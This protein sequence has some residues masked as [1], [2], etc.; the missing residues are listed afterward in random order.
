VRR[1]THRDKRSFP[2]EHQ[3]LPYGEAMIDLHRLTIWRAV[4]ASGSVS[5]AAANLGYTPA[6]VSQ[7]IITLQHALGL[8]LYERRGRGIEPTP[9]GIRVAEE[10]TEL[11]TSAR[12]LEHVL[13]DL[14]T[15]GS[16]QLSIGSFASAAKAWLPEVVVGLTC[17]FPDV[18][19]AID[20]HVPGAGPG[21]L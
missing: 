17:D 12:R 3:T 6:T 14:R 11:F 16:P 4:V 5:G 1:S 10:A 9:V 15:G 7:H 13:E 8:T 2:D 19:L 21:E 20:V 18:Q